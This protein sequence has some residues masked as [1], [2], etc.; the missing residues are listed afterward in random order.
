M[1]ITRASIMIRVVCVFTGSISFHPEMEEIVVID[2]DLKYD[3][4]V[5]FC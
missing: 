2:V 3:I 4:S 1:H 5:G